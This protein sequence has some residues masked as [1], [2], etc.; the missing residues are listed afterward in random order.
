MLAHDSFGL[1]FDTLARI[2][3]RNESNRLGT[4]HGNA[5]HKTAN[6]L[7]NSLCGLDFN[8][9]G[10]R[11]PHCH[12]YQFSV[13]RELR[14]IGEKICRVYVCNG[15]SV[16]EAACHNICSFVKLECDALFDSLYDARCRDA[17]CWQAWC[18]LDGVMN[19]LSTVLRSDV[20]CDSACCV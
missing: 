16:L 1:R 18:R 20:S 9:L 19:C 17:G 2:L 13:W 7:C 14:R 4:L 5:V 6:S 15:S 12:A 11:H 10:Q 8:M 3:W